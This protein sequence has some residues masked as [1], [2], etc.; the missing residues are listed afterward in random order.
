MEALSARALEFLILTASRTAEV[1]WATW[2]E[3]DLDNSLW[4]IPAERMK[5]QLGHMILL[6]SE[7]LA[8]LEPLS[9]GRVSNF[10]FPGQKPRQPLSGMAMKMP[11]KRMKIKGASVHGFRS[12]FRDWCGDETSF[13]REIHWRNGG[14]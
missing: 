9:E 13:P 6:T 8:I 1:L 14:D 11:I 3:F 10:V 4:V 12:T 7:A 5:A 2:D